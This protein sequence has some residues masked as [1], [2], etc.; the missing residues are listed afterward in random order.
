MKGKYHKGK[1]KTKKGDYR[2]YSQQ[3][4]GKGYTSDDQNY[5]KGKYTSRPYNIK[6][7]GKSY[8]GYTNNSSRPKGSYNN[9]GRGKG[10]G[11]RIK[12]EVVLLQRFTTTTI[13]RKIFNTT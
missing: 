6:G 4:K 8:K 5:Q 1:G 2:D 12:R 10:N 11:S 7:K 13:Q 9:Y 3:G